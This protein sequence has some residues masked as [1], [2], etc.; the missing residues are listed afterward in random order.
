MIVGVAGG[1][2]LTRVHRVWE[3][4]AESLSDR[5]SDYV[6]ELDERISELEDRVVKPVRVK[7][8]R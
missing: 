2:L 8:A 4:D 5:L 3:E 7:R 1:I 6:G